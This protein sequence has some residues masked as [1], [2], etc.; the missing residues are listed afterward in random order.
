MAERKTGWGRAVMTF[1]GLNWLTLFGSSLT[2]ASALAII[3]FVILGGLNVV[4]TL[5]VGI[6]AFLVLPGFFV[7]GLLLIPLGAWWH[8]RGQRK[9]EAEP[10]AE[11]PAYPVID[12]NRPHT[13][14]IA[15]VVGILTFVNLLIISTVSYGG[16]VYMESPEFC[17]LVCHQVMEPEYVSYTNSPHARVD[18]V[19]CHIGPGA[20]W[21]VRSKLSG[22]GQVFAVAFDSY[23]KPI[24]TPVENLRPS[25]DTCEQCHWPERFSGDRI[26]VLTRFAEDEVNTRTETVLLMHIGGANADV[27][28]IHS[29]HIDPNKETTYY[30]DH[31]KRLSIP[32]V[33]VKEA[34]GTITEYTRDGE[35]ADEAELAKMEARRMDCIDCHNR[36]THI[37]Q[38]PE[39]ALDDALAAGQIDAEIP[40]IKR[41]AA[42]ALRQA[43][44]ST[45][46][47]EALAKNV[48]AFYESE[49]PDVLASHKEGIDRAIETMRAIYERNVFPHMEVTWGTYRSHLGHVDADP[50]G[51]STEVYGCFR[52]HD[53]SH[54]SVGGDRVISQDCTICHTVLAWEEE[55]PDILVQL[56]LTGR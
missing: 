26:R 46:D 24:A 29:W 8:Y 48:Y 45:G 38:M 41:A 55:N 14:R 17:G 49:S 2:T 12:F 13:R 56:G 27:D 39:D 37:F 31:E 10:V 47:L 15:A 51:E 28:G 52:C 23:H 5:Y 18:C 6:M 7:L 50:S 34:D 40:Y 22:V 54:I 42:E 33:R 25:Q 53:D 4:D 35:P 3:A 32:V 21:F 30:T 19:E 9:R 20:P 43:T 36:P 44:G 11:E 1:F 16:V